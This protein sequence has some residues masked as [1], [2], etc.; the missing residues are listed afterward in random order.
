MRQGVL[1]AV[2]IA[3]LTALAG[4]ATVVVI[5]DWSSQPRG[6]R[7]IPAGWQGQSWGHP[8]YDMTIETDGGHHALHLKSRDDGSTISRAIK[9]KV[10]LKQ[11][12]ILEWRWKAVVLP[13]GGDSRKKELDDEAAQIYVAWERFPK[14]VR[15]RVI[16][17]V[18][19]ST[20]PIGTITKGEKSVI[21]I[22]YVVVRS[23]PEELGKWLTERRSVRD[24]FK[25]I[26]GE[27][28]DDPDA[29]SIGI[30]SNDTHSTA[31]SSIGSILFR[32]P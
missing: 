9:G 20:A 22:H 7:G 4:A 11:T 21:A 29:I 14:Q 27:E 6:V 32:A 23:G 12:P 24:D 19:D 28:P 3:G 18:W 1:L 2:L 13:K 26:Y 17:Y 15:S 30:D 10:D 5:E 8:T 25:K 31:E 16:G